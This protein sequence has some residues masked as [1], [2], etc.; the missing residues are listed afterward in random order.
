L[1]LDLK[2]KKLW[3]RREAL[4][5]MPWSLILLSLAIARR[6]EG[7]ADKTSGMKQF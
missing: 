3:M 6:C 2:K 1:G 4:F 5:K 7:L